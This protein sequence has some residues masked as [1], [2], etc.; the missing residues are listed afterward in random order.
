ADGLAPPALLVLT[1][2]GVVGSDDRDA[3]RGGALGRIDHDEGLHEPLVDRLAERLDQEE[4]AT[5]DRDLEPRVDLTGR[6]GAVLDGSR[7]RT[8]ALGD[9]LG[10]LGVRAASRDDETLLRLRDDA[11]GHAVVPVQCNGLLLLAHD[12]PL[13][14]SFYSAASLLSAL[15][16]RAAASAAP[17]PA[18]FFSTHPSMLR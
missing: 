10:Q 11:R 9:G 7:L 14:C 18:R 3:L 6:E 5:A 13:L 2:I 16:A 1:G 17:V 12:L 8:E 15:P 4:I